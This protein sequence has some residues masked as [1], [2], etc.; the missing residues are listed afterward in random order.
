MLQAE[1]PTVQEKAD[2]PGHLKQEVAW[3]S[4]RKV[5]EE[6]ES[7]DDQ[8]CPLYACHTPADV[9]DGEEM[10]EE[11]ETCQQEQLQR[12]ERGEQE[13]SQRQSQSQDQKQKVE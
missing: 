4:L 3:K 12:G 8:E 7:C 6:Q 1:Q 2:A 5:R 9:P 13:K 11:S 10:E